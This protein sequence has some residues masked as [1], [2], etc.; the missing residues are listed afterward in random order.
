MDPSCK[1]VALESTL[2]SQ[3]YKY[4][5][6]PKS[7]DG[8]GAPLAEFLAGERLP[9]WS[10]LVK[11]QVEAPAPRGN[12]SKNLAGALV[13][14]DELQK[15]VALRPRR[16]PSLMSRE[17]ALD[18][19]FRGP[20]KTEC[21]WT[22][23]YDMWIPTFDRGEYSH[24][25]AFGGA[26]AHCLDKC[27]QDPSC[28]GLALEST[29]LYQCYKYSHV[30]RGLSERGGRKLGNGLWLQHRRQAWSILVKKSHPTAAFHQPE[31]SSRGWSR[32]RWWKVLRWL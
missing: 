9:E 31:A 14:T 22:V 11:R 19:R 30:P 23:H 12:A 5:E 28:N 17:T 27:C 13:L 8:P 21:E 1:G 7:L 26:H 24:D 18:K 32:H 3:C 10:V 15:A 29:E 6:A 2:D 16:S 25:D 20:S 4:A